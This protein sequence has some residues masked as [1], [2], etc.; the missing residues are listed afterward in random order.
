MWNATIQ[1]FIFVCFLDI[2]FSVR[3]LSAYVKH[4]FLYYVKLRRGNWFDSSA[5]DKH[6][7]TTMISNL[8]AKKK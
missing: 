6:N 5:W 7:K 3:I 1:K 2:S 8:N 4:F